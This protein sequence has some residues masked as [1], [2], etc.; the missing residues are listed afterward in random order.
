MC[1]I[2]GFCYNFNFD[3]LIRFNSVIGL[4]RYWIRGGQFHTIFNFGIT[5]SISGRRGDFGKTRRDVKARFGSQYLGFK[6]NQWTKKNRLCRRLFDHWSHD[7]ISEIFRNSKT[8]NTWSFK[9]TKWII[10]MK[11]KSNKFHEHMHFFQLAA[12]YSTKRI[13]TS[14]VRRCMIMAMTGSIME[15]KTYNLHATSWQSNISNL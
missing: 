8:F 1:T 7:I 10:K 6:N 11:S 15:C 14:S 13:E 4:F 12:K 5:N 9:K 2:F 3:Q